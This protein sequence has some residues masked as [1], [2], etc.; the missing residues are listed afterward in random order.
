MKEKLLIV[1][2]MTLVLLTVG[3][4]SGCMETEVSKPLGGDLS[5][6]TTAPYGINEVSGV[7]LEVIGDTDK[8]ELISCVAST[9]YAVGSTDSYEWVWSPG[10]YNGTNAPPGTVYN[11]GYPWTGSVKIQGTIKNIAGRSVWYGVDIALYY[12]K[13][14][15][16]EE[17]CQF[18]PDARAV[19]RNSET[20]DFEVLASSGIR[21]IRIQLSAGFAEED[22]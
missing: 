13:Y 2:G 10:F 5:E 1:V 16:F 14:G 20:C 22:G 11:N 8:L 17:D 21:E 9:E 12:N 3:L 4:I 15:W 7:P 6:V 19:L 18:S